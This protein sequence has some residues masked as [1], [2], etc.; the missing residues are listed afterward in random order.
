M[1]NFGVNA[2][3]CKNMQFYL[4]DEDV[5]EVCLA[6]RQFR[7]PKCLLRLAQ[8]AAKWAADMGVTCFCRRIAA[9][10][11]ETAGK[12]ECLFEVK[13]G[14]PALKT[15]ICRGELDGASLPTGGLCDVTHAFVEVKWQGALPFVRDGCLVLPSVAETEG[16]AVDERTFLLRSCVAVKNQAERILSILGEN[17]QVTCIA[18]FEQEYYLQKKACDGRHYC[19]RPEGEI[20]ALWRLTEQKLAEMGI[21]VQSQHCEG[22]K[23]QYELVLQPMLMPEACD[24]NVTANQVLQEVLGQCDF[25]EKPY[26]NDCGS[27]KHNNWSLQTERNLLGKTSDARQQAVRAVFI[28]AAAMAAQYADLLCFGGASFANDLRL[29]EME[30][31]CRGI[32][33]LREEGLQRFLKEGKLGEDIVWRQY[34]QCRDRTAALAVVGDRLEFRLPGANCSP[35]RSGTFFNAA[36]AA[37]LRQLADRLENAKDVYREAS[38]AAKQAFEQKMQPPYSAEQYAKRI[39][40]YADLLSELAVFRKEE[41]YALSRAHLNFYRKDK[42]LFERKVVLAAEDFLNTK[43]QLRKAARADFL[44][45]RKEVLRL[46][47][48][49]KDVQNCLRILRLCGES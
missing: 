16:Y 44:R 37:A 11:G 23:S 36:M 19:K 30:A 28:A 45:R 40:N 35:Y 7:A 27:G 21:A 17:A 20:A 22:G 47:R 33:P 42:Q 5:R 3:D 26:I 25:S 38:C 32:T 34:P 6:R 10:D 2:F 49:V 29:G 8:G 14:L 12:R 43:N 18:G 46:L 39:T 48:N 31:P 1:N 24:A 9:W 41:L 15:D 13:E 4:S